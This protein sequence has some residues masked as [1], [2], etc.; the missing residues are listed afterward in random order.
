MN[1][2]GLIPP[3]VK[4]IQQLKADNDNLRSEVEELR[5]DVR[6]LSRKP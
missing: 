6:A 1:Y 5:R 3:M 2:I 4:A